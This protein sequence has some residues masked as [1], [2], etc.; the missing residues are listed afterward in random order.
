[1]KNGKKYLF[2]SVLKIFFSGRNFIKLFHDHEVLSDEDVESFAAF[3]LDQKAEPA[4]RKIWDRTFFKYVDFWGFKSYLLKN[5]MQKVT[6]FA[7]LPDET[8]SRMLGKFL[9]KN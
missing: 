9:Y 7:K 3:L 5:N 4:T 1:M 8:V 2:K 6:G